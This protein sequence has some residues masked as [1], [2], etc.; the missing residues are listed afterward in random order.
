MRMPSPLQRTTFKMSR[1]QEFFT[2]HKLQT[3]IGCSPWHWGIALTKELIDNALDACESAEVAPA[4][5]LVQDGTRLTVQDNGCGL[6]QTTLERSLNYRG[7]VSD[8]AN[9]VSPT[10][11]QLGNAL[12]CVWAATYVLS[13]NHKGCVTV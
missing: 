4:I 2:E 3:Q 10:R 7:G 6:P 9:Y 13:E 11:G 1:A 8:K 5:T 12:Q